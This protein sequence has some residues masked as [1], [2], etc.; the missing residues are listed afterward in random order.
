MFTSTRHPHARQLRRRVLLAVPTA[1]VVAAMM[2]SP[3]I[4]ATS[5]P[6]TG[7]PVS[8]PAPAVVGSTSQGI[9]MRDGGICDPIRHMGC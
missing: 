3:A 6:A 7:G 2:G 1:A 5:T 9:I 8:A 4:A